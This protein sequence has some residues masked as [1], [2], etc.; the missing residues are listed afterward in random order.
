M[1]KRFAATREVFLA[2]YRVNERGEVISPTGTV[3]KL[4]MRLW[5]GQPRLQRLLEKLGFRRE[6][7]FKNEEYNAAGE[8]VGVVSLCKQL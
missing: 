1:S 3:R 4:R 8:L 5:D 6:A 7:F 2:G